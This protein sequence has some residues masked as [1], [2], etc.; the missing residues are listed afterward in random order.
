MTDAWFTAQSNQK[1]HTHQCRHARKTH[2]TY[3]GR[4]GA[5]GEVALGLADFWHLVLATCPIGPTPIIL[6]VQDRGIVLMRDRGTPLY[7]QCK[8]KGDCSVAHLCH[9]IHHS[10]PH[11]ASFPAQKASDL[12]LPSAT[13]D[14]CDGTQNPEIY[15]VR[16]SSL[17]ISTLWSAPK[18]FLKENIPIQWQDCSKSLKGQIEMY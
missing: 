11:S 14:F 4:W 8:G 12:P 17:R 13:T 1:P 3:Y 2:T 15:R 16:I 10:L 6:L 5:V 7:W 18:L 9:W